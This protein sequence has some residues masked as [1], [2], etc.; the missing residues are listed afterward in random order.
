QLRDQEMLDIF[1]AVRKTQQLLAKIVKP[2]G[3][4]IGINI[5]KDAGAGIPGHLHIHIVPRWKGD[6][7]FMP[8]IANTK[9]ISQS[10][11]DLLTKLHH[12]YRTTA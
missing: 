5:S 2:H 6:T 8:V 11:N 9:I 1:K 3:F 10:L 4:N 12:A 7:N